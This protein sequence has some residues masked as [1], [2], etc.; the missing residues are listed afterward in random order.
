MHS[1]HSLFIFLFAMTFGNQSGAA[2]TIQ[3]LAG[4]QVSIKVMS[5]H[6]EKL[7]AAAKAKIKVNHQPTDIGVRSMING[8][9]DGAI[10]SEPKMSLPLAEK[11]GAPPQKIEDYDWTPVV[12]FK[13]L[14][15]IHPEVTSTQLTDDQIK[16]ILGGKIKNW[17]EI[18]GQSLP[19]TLVIAKA[20]IQ[21]NKAMFRHFIGSESAAPGC[22]I[23]EVT[24]RNGLL[25][26]MQSKPGSMG[27]LGGV[28]TNPD[29]KP[30]YFK[31]SAVH[32]AGL[33]I[34][35]TAKGPVRDLF[36]YLKAN[37]PY[38]PKE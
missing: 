23:L 38:E 35:K 34:K 18:S 14:F 1:N 9:V 8:V 20:Y 13:V 10:A 4:G 6:Q 31:T 11:K 3:L 24:D 37:G 12:S 26:A 30:N 5:D 22:E 21:T 32:S 19:I 25:K 36:N 7:E 17:K 28:E 2:D 16:G 33:M 29:F 27:I 15:A